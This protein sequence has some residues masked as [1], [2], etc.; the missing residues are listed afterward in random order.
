MNKWSKYKTESSLCVCDKPKWTKQYASLKKIKNSLIRMAER[1]SIL[2]ILFYKTIGRIRIFHHFLSKKVGVV[3][4]TT[5]LWNRKRWIWYGFLCSLPSFCFLFYFF[6][7][8]SLWASKAWKFVDP[9]SPW[10]FKHYLQLDLRKKVPLPTQF[11]CSV[12]MLF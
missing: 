9:S 7:V 11:R 6:S 8:F 5:N 12:T 4:F 2:R 10:T 3:E 1:K